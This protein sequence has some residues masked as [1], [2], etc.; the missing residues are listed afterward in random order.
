MSPGI[1]FPADLK[2][3]FRFDGTQGS[4][5]LIH[6]FTGIPNEVRPMAE[7]FWEFGFAVSAPL[8]PG[9]GKDGAAI[10]ETDHRQWASAVKTAL[11]ALP[12]Q[13]PT[14]IAGVS[15]G[16]LLA[17]CLAAAQPVDALVLIAPA[18]E[19]FPDGKMGI[20]LSKMG[21]HHLIPVLEKAEK[22]GDMVDGSAQ[23]S[24]PNTSEIPIR[25]LQELD[26][27]RHLATQA[28]SNI[29]APVFIAHGE[30]DRTI[31]A[32]IS[33]EVSE[34]LIKAPEVTH[35]RFPASGHVLPLDLEQQS[36]KQALRL[37][38]EEM[39]RTP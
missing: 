29:R 13:Q 2:A 16:A 27:L 24:N 35:H 6:G 10:N 17:T 22:G 23:R 21:A 36:F 5:L 12:A 11:D 39:I 7:V 19:L 9:H 8:L 1:I 37:F 3:P 4:A 32:R 14:V 34:Q 31:P 18:F 33:V 20:A 15:M 26:H 38:V 28:L 30:K 25:A